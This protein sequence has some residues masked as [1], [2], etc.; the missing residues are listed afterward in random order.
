MTDID[1]L[2][3]AL[4]DNIEPA[5]K[6]DHAKLPVH[7]VLRT[8][9]VL[10]HKPQTVQ[11]SHPMGILQAL[12]SR[13]NIRSKS[14]WLKDMDEAQRQNFIE[15][16][17][18]VNAKRLNEL[19]PGITDQLSTNL[20]RTHVASETLAA[21]NTQEWK[22]AL[23]GRGKTAQH[24][25]KE[26]GTYVLL[27]GRTQHHNSVSILVD[28]WKPWFELR[29][30]DNFNIAHEG[31]LRQELLA[32]LPDYVRRHAQLRL[33][34]PVQK[35]P[36]FGVELEENSLK[37]RTFPY[38]RVETNTP[39]VYRELT[40]VLLRKTTILNVLGFKWRPQLASTAAKLDTKFRLDTGIKAENWGV[41]RSG[42]TFVNPWAL[43]GSPR[44]LQ[45]FERQRYAL[46]RSQLHVTTGYRELHAATQ[47]FADTHIPST[48]KVA[49]DDENQSA[50][51]KFPRVNLGDFTTFRALAFTNPGLSNKY[52]RVVMC[53]GDTPSFQADKHP[54]SY[55]LCYK[56]PRD[57]L[58]AFTVLVS[59]VVN[60]DFLTGWNIF[61]HDIP[62][63]TIEYMSAFQD[64]ALR[65]SE[66]TTQDLLGDLRTAWEEHDPSAFDTSA[67]NP[68]AADARQLHARLGRVPGLLRALFAYVPN[69][70]PDLAKVLKTIPDYVAE[71]FLPILGSRLTL[72]QIN[73]LYGLLISRQQ[74]CRLTMR[75]A[76]AKKLMEEYPG[77]D[78]KA[79]KPGEVFPS[80]FYMEDTP[81]AVCRAL[82]IYIEGQANRSGSFRQWGLKEAFQAAPNPVVER[83]WELYGSRLMKENNNMDEGTHEKLRASFEALFQTEALD[84]ATT[85]PHMFYMN[86][87]GSEP[88]QYVVK[89]MK[90]GAKG[91]NKYG[92]LGFK[93]GRGDV[94]IDIMDL[95]MFVKDEYKPA[96]N[97]L[98]FFLEECGLPG[99]IDL[100]AT[101]MFALY[102]TG[103]PEDRFVIAEYARRDAEGPLDIM[104]ARAVDLTLRERASTTN[105]LYSAICN[106]GQTVRS[107][108]MLLTRCKNLAFALNLSTSQWVRDEIDIERV[109]EYTESSKEK[110]YEGATVIDAK[111]GYHRTQV[112]A[113]DFASLY[114]SIMRTF[115]LDPSLQ[116][117][118]ADAR[119]VMHLLKTAPKDFDWTFGGTVDLKKDIEELVYRND[120][121]EW[122]VL[123]DQKT[124]VGTRPGVEEVEILQNVATGVRNSDIQYRQVKNK[125]FWA[126]FLKGVVEQTLDDVLSLRKQA[127][128][129][130]AKAEEQYGQDSMQYKIQNARQLGLKVI[131]NSLYGFFGNQNN[132]LA[133]KELAAS[134][135][136]FGRNIIQI[137]QDKVNEIWGAVNG[138]VATLYGDTDSVMVDFGKLTDEMILKVWS[139]TRKE[140][141]E[142]CRT[143]FEHWKATCPQWD[144]LRTWLAGEATEEILN[145]FFRETMGMVYI[146]IELEKFYYPYLLFKKKNYA[147]YKYEGLKIQ[148]KDTKQFLRTPIIPMPKIDKKGIAAVRRDKAPMVKNTSEKMLEELLIQQSIP[149]AF[150][151]LLETLKY[152][153]EADPTSPE[154]IS[155][156]QFSKTTK[157]SYS[158]SK[159]LPEAAILRRR[160]L[161]RGDDEVPPI[162]GRLPI[163]ILDR[164]AE[165][166]V[167]FIK[168]YGEDLRTMNP[169]PW[170]AVPE[171][172]T[173]PKTIGLRAEDPDFA[174]QYGLPLDKIYYLKKLEKPLLSLIAPMQ[175]SFP[176]FHAAFNALEYKIRNPAAMKTVLREF[177]M[178]EIQV[179]AIMQLGKPRKCRAV[180]D[181]CYVDMYGKELSVIEGYARTVQHLLAH[182]R[183]TGLYCR[184]YGMPAIHPDKKSAFME[185]QTRLHQATQDSKRLKKRMA[186]YESSSSLN[187]G[188]SPHF[189]VSM[190]TTKQPRR[191]QPQGKRRRIVTKKRGTRTK[192]VS[193]FGNA[194][195]FGRM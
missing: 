160:R 130:M 96:R 116:L 169:R 51:G 54:D 64:G 10:E 109:L 94:D 15:N 112:G 75:A 5:L 20:E 84:P 119:R 18:T 82:R 190:A 13:Y 90:S 118:A 191:S 129:E 58:E 195:L 102:A 110:G 25:P 80:D 149:G 6:P 87:F 153:Y 131:A 125:F 177:S 16:W 47:A 69:K 127:K 2:Y 123:R 135:T 181:R 44:T 21:K 73:R 121:Q 147:G 164:H 133:C 106:S 39:T 72:R 83:A 156:L 146:I 98:N 124:R 3:Q 170:S 173:V 172:S 111:S 53:V 189:G 62:F 155:Q 1:G 187:Q 150:Q 86:T 43:D 9:K 67:N 35:A 99:K 120:L 91:D 66:K 138:N 31:A 165:Y 55:I 56:T 188:N 89:Y 126:Q 34:G 50:T 76:L 57:M 46:S 113:L 139:D 92:M 77:T 162:G 60:I 22:N 174:Q 140:S 192:M 19:N 167:P 52:I 104:E 144:I 128:G 107:I 63:S 142:E 148:D 179:F 30:P 78:D 95:M 24:D 71:E 81:E 182:C 183:D 163:C 117:S 17:R 178:D 27:R 7:F 74:E 194:G 158:K 59:Q 166:F 97:G 14:A 65:L 186:S 41:I 68:H 105:T 45:G 61:G 193:A 157:S 184:E 93:D 171:K 32:K 151:I 143:M 132:P 33:V 23:F 38:V 108:N 49:F 12:E 101:E 134:V 114:P 11:E 8:C 136:W 185:L 122:Q 145:T 141:A 36:F 175:E 152:F 137:T 100:K 37:R 154:M 70:M 103:K 115:K 28:D 180:F 85:Q 159:S 26:R 79:L 42:R 88:T 4:R 161:K 168:K 40:N 29:L 48:V 176:L